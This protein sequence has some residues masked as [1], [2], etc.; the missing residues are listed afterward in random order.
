MS[1]DGSEFATWEQK[2][3]ELRRRL[4]LKPSRMDHTGLLRHPSAEVADP[5][6]LESRIGFRFEFLQLAGDVAPEMLVD[7]GG[8]PLDAYAAEWERN[9]GPPDPYPDRSRVDQSDLFNRYLAKALRDGSDPIAQWCRRWGFPTG[10]EILLE[11]ARNPDEDPLALSAMRGWG[12]MVGIE[13][14]HCW[15]MFAVR[16]VEELQLMD[17]YFFVLASAIADRD[18][19]LDRALNL[20][21]YRWNPQR[22]S[23]ATASARILG[24]MRRSILRELDRIEAETRTCAVAVPVRRAGVEH[25]VWL[26]RYQLRRES[27]SEIARSVCRSRQSVSDAIDSAAR[28]IGLPLRAPDPPGR[29]ARPVSTPRI[30]RFHRSRS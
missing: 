21:R 29:P 17:I 6:G 13:T 5:D 1:G 7:L 9:G 16:A 10:H 19:A 30:V 14:V 11:L 2:R 25:F 24:E 22:E 4:R 8:A 27:I 28:L 26:A 18:L 3:D 20:P 12:L 15:R 23:R